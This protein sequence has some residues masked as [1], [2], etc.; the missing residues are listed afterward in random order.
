MLLMSTLPLL[1]GTLAPV[2]EEE[3]ANAAEIGSAMGPT[4]WIVL[5]VLAVIL[6]GAVWYAT[7]R[8]QPPS[9]HA[10]EHGSAQADSH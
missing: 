4:I 10:G 6:T 7:T 1:I 8:I 9:A 3:T 5:M 2:L